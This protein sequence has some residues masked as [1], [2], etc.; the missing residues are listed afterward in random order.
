VVSQKII[1]KIIKHLKV[2]NITTKKMLKIYQ[3]GMMQRKMDE[4]D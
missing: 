2:K 4:S 3:N 1:E